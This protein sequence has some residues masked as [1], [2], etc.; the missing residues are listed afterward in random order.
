M[1]VFSNIWIAFINFN[2]SLKECNGVYN[3]FTITT[4]TWSEE[5]NRVSLTGM[6]HQ[7]TLDAL[8]FVQSDDSCQACELNVNSTLRIKLL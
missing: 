3:E 1:F 7:I 2:V 4:V 6:D 8:R 5:S